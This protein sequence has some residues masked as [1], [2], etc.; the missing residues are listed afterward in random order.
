[1]ATSIVHAKYWGYTLMP[2]GMD[3]GYIASYDVDPETPLVWIDNG[4]LFERPNSPVIPAR[5]IPVLVLADNL[6]SEVCGYDI[7]VFSNKCIVAEVFRKDKE[8]FLRE[9]FQ[10]YHGKL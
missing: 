2:E 10:A 1:M 4:Y 5:E 8:K 3:S 9:C 6:D 7:D